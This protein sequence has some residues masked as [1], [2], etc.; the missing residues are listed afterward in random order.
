M[1]YIDQSARAYL[2]A[3]GVEHAPSRVRKAGELNFLFTG[4]AI[5]TLSSE[6][7]R[8]RLYSALMNVARAYLDSRERTYENINT[9]AGALTL[10]ALEFRRRTLRTE[11]QHFFDMAIMDIYA[12]SGVDYERDAIAR[13]GD[14]YPSK[15]VRAT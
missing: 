12:E 13:N 1:P 7:S 9:C 5:A 2:A 8:H 11:Y 10:A 14:V 6:G 4:L 3:A 15:F